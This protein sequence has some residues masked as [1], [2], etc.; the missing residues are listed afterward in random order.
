[1]GLAAAL[2]EA[3]ARGDAARLASLLAADARD[4]NITDE[5]TTLVGTASLLGCKPTSRWHRGVLD[6][7]IY[8][9][10]GLVEC[11]QTVAEIGLTHH[12]FME[13]FKAFNQ[14]DHEKRRYLNRSKTSVKLVRYASNSKQFSL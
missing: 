10:H 14:H 1:M 8:L 2:L 11:C 4:I 9:Q 13:Y 5:V 12:G 6:L 3:A 7:V